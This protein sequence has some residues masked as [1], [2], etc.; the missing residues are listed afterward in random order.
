MKTTRHKGITKIDRPERQH[1]GYMVRVFWQ[2][3]RYQSFFSIA[4]YGDWLAALD[5]AVGWRDQ[6]EREIGKPRTEQP[7]FSVANAESGMLGI[8]RVHEHG[9]DY[10]EATWREVDEEGRSF[11]RRTRYSVRKHGERRALALALKA[12]KQGEQRRWKTAK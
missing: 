7:V 11:T 8:S 1:V 9:T 4:R 2:G 10:I 6:T 3:K 12:R 5:A